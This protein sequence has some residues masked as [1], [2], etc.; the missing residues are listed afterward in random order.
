M[1]TTRSH[2]C[3]KYTTNINIYSANHNE[4]NGVF[5]DAQLNC[6]ILDL[7]VNTVFVTL[8]PNYVLPG[9]LKIE[10]QMRSSRVFSF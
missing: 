9:L 10:N 2:A 1:T 7:E 8:V 6:E 3:Y 5:R 4:L